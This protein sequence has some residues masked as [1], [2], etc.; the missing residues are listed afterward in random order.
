[1]EA[2]PESLEAAAGETVEIRLDELASGGFGWDVESA[3]PGLIVDSRAD[4]PAG[5]PGA[6]RTR[7][8]L[9]RATEPG[10]YALA[11]RYGRPWEAEPHE[12]REYRIRVT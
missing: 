3:E 12:R 2:V 5:A 9:V 7:R 1:M 8:L 4:P 11:L 6:A 10:E